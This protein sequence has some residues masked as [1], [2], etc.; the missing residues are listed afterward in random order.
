MPTDV[1]DVVHSSLKHLAFFVFGTHMPGNVSIEISNF[2][3]RGCLSNREHAEEAP[4]ICAA[5]DLTLSSGAI[6]HPWA[7]SFVQ[8]GSPCVC[9]A[10]RYLP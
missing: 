9:A 10:R 7:A 1:N 6:P 5:V 2:V 4:K 8:A 3:T